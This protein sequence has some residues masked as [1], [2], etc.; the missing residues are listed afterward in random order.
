[1]FLAF[2]LLSLIL[3]LLSGLVLSYLI[4]NFLFE[5]LII[6][7]TRFVMRINLPNPQL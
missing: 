6:F 2:L 5:I 1:M 3:K 4:F 7:S